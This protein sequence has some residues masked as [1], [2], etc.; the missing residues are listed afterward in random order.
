MNEFK[1]TFGYKLIYIFRI[2]DIAHKDLLKIGEATV[3][4]ER[5]P[6]E[7]NPNCNILNVAA[8]NRINQYTTTAGIS[9]D[10]LYTELAIRTVVKNGKNISEAF[11]D[12]DV[13]NVLKRSEIKRHVFDIDG[14]SNE[15]FKVDLETA[16]KAICAVKEGRS[17]LLSSEV[18]EGRSPIIFRPEQAEA[19]RKTIKQF[20]TGNQMLWNA[21]MRFGK[22]LTALQVA[23]ECEFKHILILTHR[24]VVSD[25]WFEDF[26]KIFYDTDYVFGSKTKGENINNLIDT[27]K[28]FVYFVSMQDLRGSD[29]V[30][31]KFNKNDEIFLTKWDFVVIDEAFQ[32]TKWT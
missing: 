12:H 3:Y 31:G 32:T 14:N 25:G 9:Y 16:K 6:E 2:N 21:K 27:D 18:S 19:I 4:S 24:P 1:T 29:A 8:K 20:K 11:S 5:K 15:W 30:G 13:H 26:G 23:K 28:K 10:L 7:L 22:T 17:S